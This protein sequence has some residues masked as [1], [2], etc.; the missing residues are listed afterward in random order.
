LKDLVQKTSE[1]MKVAEQKMTSKEQ[2]KQ[3]GWKLYDEKPSIK[4][5]QT[6]TEEEYG[7][8]SLKSIPIRIDSI[9]T[10]TWTAILLFVF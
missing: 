10:E 9:W 3:E 5:S 8:S 4:G 7:V 6:W 2:Q 1:M